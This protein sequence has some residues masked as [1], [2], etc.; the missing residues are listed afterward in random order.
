MKKTIILILSLSIPLFASMNNVASVKAMSAIK[1][2]NEIH[3]NKKRI[4]EFDT[5]LTDLTVENDTKTENQRIRD[6]I[7]G[8]R[9]QFIKSIEGIN[10]NMQQGA[11]TVPVVFKAIQTGI[12]L[13]LL[14]SP[15]SIPSIRKKYDTFYE[16]A[17]YLPVIAGVMLPTIVDMSNTK[18]SISL[19]IGISITSILGEMSNATTKNK[20]D[21][22]LK[23]VSATSDVIALNR[24]VYRDMIVLDSMISN[25]LN[26]K[27][28][29]AEKYGN[30]MKRYNWKNI[31]ETSGAIKENGFD[32]YVDTSLMYFEKVTEKVNSI[33]LLI[34]Q[35]N[36]I[37]VSYNQQVVTLESIYKDNANASKIIAD[38][39]AAITN[40][41]SKVDGFNE[42]WQLLSSQCYKLNYEDKEKF[43]K[44]NEYTNFIKLIH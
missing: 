41:K 21:E 44:F 38:V 14:S 23:E 2:K 22:T 35:V 27:D 5:L 20:T 11:Y 3:E 31:N 37:M 34:F 10:T 4:Y 19:A 39:K 13:G 26:K 36:K 7:N 6:S 24:A 30:F 12:N 15:F 28:S 18:G 29:L 8:I 40:I 43:R 25:E 32:T 1:I 17:K 33:N 42:A 16:Y 9:F